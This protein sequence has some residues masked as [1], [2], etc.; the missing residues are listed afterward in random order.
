MLKQLSHTQIIQILQ[1]ERNLTY[2]QNQTC[3]GIDKGTNKES[4]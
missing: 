1:L 4:F 2:Q 3:Y